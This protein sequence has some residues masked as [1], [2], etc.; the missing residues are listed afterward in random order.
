MRFLILS[1]GSAFFCRQVAPVAN[2]LVRAGHSVQVATC[3][4]TPEIQIP[5]WEDPVVSLGVFPADD[6]WKSRIRSLFATFRMRRRL[7][8]L[9]RDDPP[10]A[11]L[12]IDVLRGVALGLQAAAQGIPT[13]VHM[14]DRIADTTVARFGLGDMDT[15]FYACSFRESVS[16]APAR[17]Y[18]TGFPLPEE[19]RG[20]KSAPL[21]V[22]PTRA[23]PAVLLVLDHREDGS[24][25]PVVAPVAAGIQARGFPLVVHHVVWESVQK[26][27]DI[28]RAAKAHCFVHGFL[29]GK[30]YAALL[31]SAHACI[32]R[33]GASDLF[34]CLSHNL[35][36]IFIPRDL[37]RFDYQRA[38][39]QTLE[40]ARV[41][42]VL[43]PAAL[44]EA[45]LEDF[46][47]AILLTPKSRRM[48]KKNME[49]YAVPNAPARIREVL[50]RIAGEG[51]RRAENEKRER[52]AD[53]LKVQA[54]IEAMRRRPW[55]R[56]AG[57]VWL[58][59]AAYAIL[60]LL[61]A[62]S[63]Y[64]GDGIPWLSW[65]LVATLVLGSF[66]T[67]RF[68]FPRRRMR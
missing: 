1:E 18:F 37:P 7:I 9:L 51:R 44:T 52:E 50:V 47:R 6:D 21:P 46:L 59:M 61:S 43:D 48:L 24:L 11:V 39:A 41:A 64:T 15:L 30:D 53:R 45:S 14:S 38:N 8:R 54:D 10:D 13:L 25:A 23:N 65:A 57:C 27:A 55:T 4:S 60:R 5:G 20:A 67:I 63:R 42:L 31:K 12:S 17:A 16:E 68:L 49:A 33:A 58:A 26:T 56:V 22:R 36:T 62:I 3:A 40:A 28:Y 32:S 29:P 35:P 66:V 19:M 34:A 2:E